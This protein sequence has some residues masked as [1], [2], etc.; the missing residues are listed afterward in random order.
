MINQSKRDNERRLGGEYRFGAA[1]QGARLVLRPSSLADLDTIMDGLSDF[2]VARMVEGASLPFLRPDAMDLFQSL[3]S[4]G[5][6]GWSFVLSIKDGPAIG[7]IWLRES[8]GAYLLQYWLNRSHWGQGYM[9]E[10]LE[11]VLRHFFQEMPEVVLRADVYADDGLPRDI[12][13]DP[14]CHGV[15]NTD[16]T[17]EDVLCW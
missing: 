4:D 9:G 6:G 11:L 2:S 3:P 10:A 1:M 14:Q 7:L 8:K 5:D 17:D 16:A 12:C 15:E 13:L